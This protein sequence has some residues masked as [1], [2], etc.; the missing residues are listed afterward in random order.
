MSP[1]RAFAATALAL[2]F[3]T[4]ALAQPSSPA[5]SP[6]PAAA[7]PSAEAPPPPRR[8]ATAEERAAA[9]RADPLAQAAFWSREVEVNPADAEAGIAMARA[10]RALGRFDEAGQAADRVLV[11]APANLDAL[12]ETARA[13]IASGQGFYAVEPLTRA[14]AAAPRDWRPANLLGVAYQQTE[15][16]AEAQAAWT[17]ALS[18]SADNPEILNNQAM[19]AAADGDLAAAETLLRR[20]AARPDA[21]VLVRQNLALV[22]GLRGNAAE[23]EALNRQ[24][25]PPE[26]VTRNLAW[27]RGPAPATTG[28][29]QGRSWESLRSAEAGTPAG[30]GD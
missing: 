26:Q 30:G 14:R 25:L 20:A 6:T 22:V 27:L 9:L 11:V 18:L 17:Q 7:Q 10:L 23:A 16:R 3:A 4:P 15:R 21:G 24:N 8:R 19:A 29:S 1:T 13:K 5:A 2:L 28:G 12:L